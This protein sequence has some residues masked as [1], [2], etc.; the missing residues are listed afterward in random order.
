MTR[1]IHITT[2]ARSLGFLRGQPDFFADRGVEMEAI[3][4]PGEYVEPMADE[5]NIPVH[6]VEMPRRIT[7]FQDLGALYEMTRLIRRLDP[8][9]VHSHTPKGGLLGVIAATMAGVPIRFYH[10]RGLPFETMTGPKRALLKTTE[11]V[12]CTLAH[13][14]VS[15]GATIRQTA[16]DEGIVPADKIDVLAGGSGQG[17]DATGRF[18]PARFDDEIGVRK[19]DEL[20]I[21]A[22]ATVIGFVGRLVRDK[23]VVELAEAF[24]RIR[25]DFEDAHLLAIGPFEQR[26]PVPERTRRLLEDDPRVHLPGFRGDVDELYMAMDLLVLP[27]HREGFPNAP[28][29]AASMEL[30]VVASDIGPCREAVA[31][32]ETGLCFP[33]G[34]AASMADRLTTYLDD[35]ALRRQH[36]KAGRE[37]VLANFLPRRIWTELAELYEKHL[38]S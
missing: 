8:D 34:D 33:V 25:D 11:T 16:V 13:Q 38:R 27:T 19:R 35:P 32:G 3:T 31:A 14:V 29:E 10:M 23:G 26:D 2:V 4:S 22:D 28:L 30:P 37:R 20:D 5:L 36:G 21:P 12:S 18:D 15:V 7:P 1:L 6:T 9:I 24:E 17:V